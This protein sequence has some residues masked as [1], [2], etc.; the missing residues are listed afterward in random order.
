MHMQYID[1]D[2]ED[3][4]AKGYLRSWIMYFVVVVAAT[5]AVI[6]M[7]LMNAF[8]NI[9]W[10]GLVA[11]PLALFAAGYFYYRNED[12]KD[13]DIVAYMAA[14]REGWCVCV[15]CR[16]DRDSVLCGSDP[17]QYI[18]SSGVRDIISNTTAGYRYRLECGGGRLKFNNHDKHCCCFA[19][20]SKC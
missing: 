19:P 20:E 14:K 3:L 17:D 8:G 11:I 4:T 7:N 16:V 1:K 5:M 15:K 6:G 12:K 13:Y 2:I 18:E 10:L 9:M